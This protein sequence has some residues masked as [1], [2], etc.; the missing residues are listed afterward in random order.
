MDGTMEAFHLAIAVAGVWGGAVVGDVEGGQQ[1]GGGTRKLKAI[2][3]ADSGRD[4][5][6]GNDVF[7]DGGG[8]GGRGAVGDELQH[9]KLAE[10]TDGCE[11][12]V[13]GGGRRAEVGDEV[14]TPLKTGACREGDQLALPRAVRTASAE[15]ALKAGGSVAVAVSAHVGPVVVLAEDMVHF[16]AADVGM[17]DVGFL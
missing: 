6:G 9:T 3:G 8:D 5:E 2:V 15:L 11:Q 4:S 12:V 14:D 10:A 17:S 16:V 7:A 13:F 1:C